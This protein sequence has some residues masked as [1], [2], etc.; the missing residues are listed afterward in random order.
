MACLR[1]KMC[2]PKASEE[3][4][5]TEYLCYRNTFYTVTVFGGFR[6]NCN[7]ELPSFC[8]EVLHWVT[9]QQKQPTGKPKLTNNRPHELKTSAPT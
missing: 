4:T 2:G 3:Y 5:S 6:I 8:N 9:P 1:R 7:I